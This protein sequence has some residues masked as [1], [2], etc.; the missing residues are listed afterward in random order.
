MTTDKDEITAMI[1]TFMRPEKFEKCIK[2]TIN[3]NISK[4]VVGYDGPEDL[5]QKHKTICDHYSDTVEIRSIKLPFNA[6]ISKTRNAMIKMVDTEFLIQLDDDN[7]IPSNILDIIPFLRNNTEI[8]AIALGWVFPN[9]FLQLDAFDIEIIEGFL[10]RTF[11]VGKTVKYYNGLPFL[12]AY[13]FIPNCGIF[14][15]AVFDDVQWDEHFIISGEHED[16]YLTMLDKDWL[17]GI[18]PSIYAYHDW[19]K[20]SKQYIDYRYGI[21]GR[22]SYDYLME[23]W[24]LKGYMPLRQHGIYL[25][26]LQ[27]FNWMLDKHRIIKNK[28]KNH[29]IMEEE[30]IVFYHE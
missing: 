16:F 7:Y 11:K 30:K 22:K 20:E 17:F 27:W 9:G 25:E 13:D 26:H 10:F 21:E 8:G 24:N 4:I 29:E 6:G 23:K 1:K 28:L 15:R 19:G 5:W 12:Y 14:K 3:A 2:A 18:C